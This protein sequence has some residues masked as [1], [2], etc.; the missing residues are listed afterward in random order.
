MQQGILHPEF[1]G[2]MIYHGFKNR[3]MSNYLEVSTNLKL[4]NEISW[5]FIDAAYRSLLTQTSDHIND[6]FLLRTDIQTV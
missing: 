6:V 3:R 2:D 5:E 1:Y 4:P